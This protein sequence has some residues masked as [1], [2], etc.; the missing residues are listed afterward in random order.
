MDTV[1]ID[2][3]SSFNTT[4]YTFT[5]P[6]AGTYVFRGYVEFNSNVLDNVDLEFRHYQSNGTTLIKTIKWSDRIRTVRSARGEA[7]FDMAA[8][9]KHKLYALQASGGTIS[10]LFTAAGQGVKLIGFKIG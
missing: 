7:I 6:V 10:T 3:T 2:T 4:N 9:E 5:A 8:G 1:E